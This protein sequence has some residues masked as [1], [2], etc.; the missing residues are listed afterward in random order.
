MEMDGLMVA[1]LGTQIASILEEIHRADI[2]HADVKP[3]NF[4]I[5]GP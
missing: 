2:I 3:D 5:T 1:L 4:V